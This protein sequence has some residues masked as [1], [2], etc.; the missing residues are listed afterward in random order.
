MAPLVYTILSL[1]LCSSLQALAEPYI[2]P[3]I[4][5]VQ[6]PQM[7]Y[8]ERKAIAEQQAKLRMFDLGVPAQYVFGYAPG[9][10]PDTF[11]T[12]K[13]TQM[14]SDRAETRLAE[15]QY[16]RKLEEQQLDVEIKKLE[17]ISGIGVTDKDVSSVYLK[18]SQAHKFF[19]H[20]SFFEIAKFYSLGN[21][22]AKRLV[23]FFS[24]SKR[25]TYSAEY[26][27]SL[28]QGIELAASKLN[29]SPQAIT[30]TIKK[31]W[32][33]GENNDRGEA[34]FQA[35]VKLAGNARGDRSLDGL[36]IGALTD[37][38]IKRTNIDY[39]KAAN[40]DQ[41]APHAAL[42]NTALYVFSPE[43]RSDVEKQTGM[44]WDEYRNWMNK[45]P[46]SKELW[47]DYLMAVDE[48][49]NAPKK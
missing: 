41:I 31:P 21:E 28:G 40:P 18:V 14:E 44:K 1:S 5:V 37:Y 26:L 33:S 46:N 39:S 43:I 35:V 11:D 42:V 47:A 13:Q 45:A 4:V 15:Q 6:Q 25:D 16:Q 30:E 29:I 27:V 9:V 34:L 36:K 2:P 48:R 24:F 17:I 12:N 8:E 49:A 19:P 3:P 10:M 32:F 23:P 7:N 38:I 20:L 22:Y